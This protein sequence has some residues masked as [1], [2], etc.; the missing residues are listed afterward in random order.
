MN[1]FIC[2]LTSMYVCVFV[3]V[4]SWSAID[5]SY[6]DN[7]DSSGKIGCGESHHGRKEFKLVVKNFNR[8]VS[9]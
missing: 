4:D 6:A 7:G 3:R 9:V 1:T 8:V 5:Y 2:V